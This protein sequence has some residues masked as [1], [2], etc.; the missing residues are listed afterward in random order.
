MNISENLN[1]TE[2]LVYIK[3]LLENNEKNDHHLLFA[4][5]YNYYI[6]IQKNLCENEMGIFFDNIEVIL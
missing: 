6:S 2:I 5:S 1:Q 3:F 4:L